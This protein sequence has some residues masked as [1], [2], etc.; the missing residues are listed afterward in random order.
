MENAYRLKAKVLTT[1]YGKILKEFEETGDDRRTA[2]N[3]YQQL[4]TACSDMEACGTENC[5][6]CNAVNMHMRE[7]ETII[8]RIVTRFTGLEYR[9]YQWTEPT[10]TESDTPTR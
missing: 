7:Q 4:L 2:W 5:F 10:E 6:I 9:N 8:D 1:K 3:C